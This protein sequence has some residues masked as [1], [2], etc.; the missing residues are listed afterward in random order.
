MNLLGPTFLLSTH[1]S[2]L[3]NIK[4]VNRST[5]NLFMDS[6]LLTREEC[7]VAGVTSEGGD[8]IPGS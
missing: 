1:N 8:I 5:E 3:P 6:V 7:D 2:L 4:K